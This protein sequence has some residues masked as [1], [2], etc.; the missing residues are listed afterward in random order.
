MILCG[1]LILNFPNFLLDISFVEISLQRP[2]DLM[3][4]DV[5]LCIDLIVFLPQSHIHSTFLSD[6]G[7]VSLGVLILS[8]PNFLLDMSSEDIIILKIIYIQVVNSNSVSV[9]FG[10]NREDDRKLVSTTDMVSVIRNYAQV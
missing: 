3:C 4:P 1:V 9:K 5:I 10:V 6:P 8:F 7:R 2:Q